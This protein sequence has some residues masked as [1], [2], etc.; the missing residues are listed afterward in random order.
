MALSLRSVR[1]SIS[2]PLVSGDTAGV[3]AHARVCRHA[4]MHVNVR[5]HTS[6][7]KYPRSTHKCNHTPQPLSSHPHIASFTPESHPR[8]S[9][10]HF[11]DPAPKVQGSDPADHDQ[12]GH[13]HGLLG[14]RY[15]HTTSCPLCFL[16]PAHC[17]LCTPYYSPRW[18]PGRI[19]HPT[20]RGPYA[21]GAGQP[22]V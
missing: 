1:N 13:V 12:L 6:L 22:L 7:G 21:C 20:P 4:H 14:A 10:Q 3:H 17:S 9:P 2:C 11:S 5:M 16:F 15:T 18:G 8:A 19:V